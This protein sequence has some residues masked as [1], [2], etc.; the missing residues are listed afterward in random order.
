MVKNTNIVKFWSD[1]TALIVTLGGIHSHF[2]IECSN[3]AMKIDEMN[4]TRSFLDH[5]KFL[6]K[7]I[8]YLEDPKLY[9]QDMGKLP[10]SITKFLA[11]YF[12]ILWEMNPEH[13]RLVKER[14]DLPH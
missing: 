10:D 13:L 3:E 12:T 2:L 4:E 8:T 5:P 6:L 14:F 11:S 9:V 1:F 7:V